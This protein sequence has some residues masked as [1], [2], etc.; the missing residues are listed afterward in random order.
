M[1]FFVTFFALAA[2]MYVAKP[3]VGAGTKAMLPIL[4]GVAT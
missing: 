2:V 4:L 1:Q 3:T